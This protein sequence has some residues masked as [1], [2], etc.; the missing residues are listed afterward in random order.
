MT[1]TTKANQAMHHKLNWVQ[2]LLK[3]FHLILSMLPYS[4]VIETVQ[5]MLRQESDYAVTDLRMQT[6]DAN[7][8]IVTSSG[9]DKMVDWCC[10]VIQ[11]C[12][13]E[14]EIVSIAMNFTDRKC[15]ANPHILFNPCKYQLVAMTALYT[16]AKIHAPEALD[17][18]LVSTLSRGTYTAKE[19][20][21]QERM[22]LTTLH[23]KVNPPTAHSFARQ[24]FELAHPALPIHDCES[25]LRF[26]LN[27]IDSYMC[28]YYCSSVI[29]PSVV[30]YCSFMN[31]LGYLSKLTSIEEDI[32]F[33][34]GY[35]IARLIDLDLFSDKIL[36][37]EAQ[38][39]LGS[40]VTESQHRNLKRLLPRRDTKQSWN[41][42]KFVD[43]PVSSQQQQ[44]SS[45]LIA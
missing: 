8:T 30:A 37:I 41:N 21:A 25:A 3:I 45:A 11:Y 5:L 22:L 32:A 9:R 18:E 39:M 34:L 29:R 31:A 12:N 4:N 35:N 14:T 15:I 36:I 43:N 20:E 1:T 38:N 44:R 24:F 10:R 19:I 6:E 2:F 42:A 13:L 27:Q 26:S 23:W 16:A 40:S 33:G 7:F 28:K 17:P